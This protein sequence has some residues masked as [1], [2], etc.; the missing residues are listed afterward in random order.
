[1]A[2]LSYYAF[3][4]L[5]LII[6]H[7]ILHNYTHYLFSHDDLVVSVWRNGHV[8]KESRKKDRQS[9]SSYSPFTYLFLLHLNI[10]IFILILY[11]LKTTK[12][13]PT[14]T[15]WSRRRSYPHLVHPCYSSK[16]QLWMHALYL[17][18]R[19]VSWAAMCDLRVQSSTSPCSRA[20]C[21][22]CSATRRPR[23]ADA[24]YCCRTQPS[25]AAYT[26]ECS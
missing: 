4:Y 2:F 17:V 21:T 19:R 16:S 6:F 10:N 13:A 3:T 14:L 8:T 15:K 1:M 22:W 25:I 24:D 18:K 23:I 7:I 11:F 12:V 9:Y 26:F 5:I 20:H